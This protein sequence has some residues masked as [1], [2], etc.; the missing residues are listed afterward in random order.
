MELNWT[1]LRHVGAILTKRREYILCLT[2]T[3]VNVQRLRVVT[4]AAVSC[5]ISYPPPSRFRC[6]NVPMATSARIAIVC[7]V[8]DDWNLEEDNKALQ[9]LKPDVVLF[10]GRC[11]LAMLTYAIRPH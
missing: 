5:A 11:F 7:D 3:H 4:R 6:S 10:T 2:A 1:K 8:H 9:L